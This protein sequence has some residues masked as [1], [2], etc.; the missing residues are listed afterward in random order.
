MMVPWTVGRAVEVGSRSWSLDIFQKNCQHNLQM[1]WMW[2]I[3]EREVKKTKS[4]S[5][6]IQKNVVT[7]Q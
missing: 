7:I 6:S 3:R 4:I 1:A 2:S 5:L